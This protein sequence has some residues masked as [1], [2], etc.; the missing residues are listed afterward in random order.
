MMSSVVSQHP[1]YEAAERAVAQIEEASDDYLNISVV[2][3]YKKV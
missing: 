1:N 2:R 3:L